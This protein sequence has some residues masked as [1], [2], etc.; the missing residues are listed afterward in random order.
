MH[1]KKCLCQAEKDGCPKI[2]FPAFGVGNLKYP[3]RE[4]AHAMISAANEFCIHAI[5]LKLKKIKFAVFM[6]DLTSEVRFN[7]QLIL[8]SQYTQF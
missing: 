8:F 1:V 2:A 4:V 3:R 6:D 7:F 5:N